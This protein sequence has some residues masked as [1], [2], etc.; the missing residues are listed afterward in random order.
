MNLKALIV[1]PRLS[2][3]GGVSNFY[4]ILKQYLK[5]DTEYFEIGRKPKEKKFLFLFRLISDYYNFQKKISQGNY[6]IVLINPSLGPL[7][8]IRDSVLI[9]IA[10]YH[11]LKILTFFRGW[12]QKCAKLI[13]RHFSTVFRSIYNLSDGFIVLSEQFRQTLKKWEITSPIFLATTIVDDKIFLEPHEKKENQKNLSILYLS[14]IEKSKGIYE[15]IDTFILLKTKHPHFKLIIAGDGHELLQV[16]EYV[17]RKG[18]HG[19]QFT[20]FVEGDKKRQLF[21][22]S[23]IF[24]FPTYYGEGMPNAILEAMAY[25]LPVI[26]RPVGGI[27]DFFENGQM[28]FIT[29]SMEPIIFMHLLEKLALDKTL[30]EKIGRYNKKYAKK[31][32]SATKVAAHLENIYKQLMANE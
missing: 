26:T 5:T 15:A 2:L 21:L 6:H 8:I 19:I 31:H 3:L 28:G 29:E 13:E 7:S 25:G 12:D 14:R 1:V 4:N 20:G 23:H 27:K 11:K 32:F 17:I 16:K 18:V 24:I 9:G 10:K 22:N 30:R